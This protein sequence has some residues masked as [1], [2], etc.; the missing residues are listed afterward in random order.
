MLQLLSS[1][2]HLTRNEHRKRSQLSL[3]EGV[4]V[5]QKSEALKA[6]PGAS[7]SH[8]VPARLEH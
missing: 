5:G 2:F 8:F 4:S 6:S 7:S 3:R 1:I